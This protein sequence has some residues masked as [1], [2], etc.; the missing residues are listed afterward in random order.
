MKAQ[1]EFCP[2]CEKLLSIGDGWGEKRIEPVHG[3][4]IEVGFSA[5]GWGSRQDIIRRFSEEI[6]H[7]CFVEVSKGVEFIKEIFKARDGINRPDISA[8]TGGDNMPSVRDDKLSSDGCF[9]KV[10]R[11]LSQIP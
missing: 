4:C 3:F 2:I 6:C 9:T 8:T 10:L 11:K 1:L 7:E 5:G